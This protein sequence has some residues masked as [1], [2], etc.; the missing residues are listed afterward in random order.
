MGQGMTG[1]VERFEFDALANLD[2]I[3][4][5][6]TRAL[7]RRI[8]HNLLYQHTA[9]G[10]TRVLL[11][12]VLVQRIATIARTLHGAGMNHRDF[13]LCHFLTRDRA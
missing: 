11:K 6:E 13:Y 2:H 1:S 12:R 10:R 9:R 3:T 7:G 8:G 5:L 4:R